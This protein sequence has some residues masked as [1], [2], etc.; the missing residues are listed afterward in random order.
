[1][2]TP[3]LRQVTVM[4]VAVMGFLV[5]FFFVVIGGKDSEDSSRTQ[6]PNVPVVPSSPEVV[7]PPETSPIVLS[8]EMRIA[9]L[10]LELQSLLKTQGKK[11]DYQSAIQ[12]INKDETKERS[13]SRP[14]PPPTNG[15][16]PLVSLPNAWPVLPS[17][18]KPATGKVVRL[19]KSQY[20][21]TPTI[22]IGPG[23]DIKGEEIFPLWGEDFIDDATKLL[24]QQPYD[25]PYDRPED[26]DKNAKPGSI[27]HELITNYRNAPIK[28]LMMR[29]QSAMCLISAVYTGNCKYLEESFTDCA[30]RLG[31][32]KLETVLS[33]KCRISDLWSRTRSATREMPHPDADLPVVHGKV[34][35]SE[36]CPI[37]EAV[38]FVPPSK[39]TIAPFGG[40][41]Q[42]RNGAY[43]YPIAFGTPARTVQTK[44]FPKLFD[45]HPIPV[46]IPPKPLQYN[47]EDTYQALAALSHF[48]ITHSRGGW[49]CGRHY[50]V[51]SAG[52]VPYFYDIH[53]AG[54]FILP[55]LPKKFLM[56]VVK[57]PAMAH[58]GHVT[59]ALN[60]EYFMPTVPYIK[61]DSFNARARV[62]FVNES[63]YFN[64]DKFDYEWYWKSARQFLKY[65]QKYL[66][67]EAMAAYVLK[68]M[69][70]E[71]AKHVLI[72]TRSAWD[73]LHQ[74]FI[75]GLDGLGIKMTI[76]QE[77]DDE[78][79]AGCFRHPSNRMISSSSVA[80][81]RGDIGRGG[82]HGNGV[83]WANRM[84]NKVHRYVKRVSD[85]VD[86]IEFEELYDAAIFTYFAEGAFPLGLVMDLKAHTNGKVAVLDHDDSMGD[87]RRDSIYLAKEVYFFSRELRRAYC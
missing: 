80:N 78:K 66:T 11:I 41:R 22:P 32:E 28:V 77:N 10:Q 13:A 42:C 20:V 15:T 82:L 23:H 31:P 56:D 17:F 79:F 18:R 40:P 8:P 51:A 65:T 34:P 3:F 85:I 5:L 27:W 48:C 57:Q 37:D 19:G 58:I 45:F 73:N 9:K 47:D 67:T 81:L 76:V 24:Y 61:K 59:G 21:P 46:D 2:R 7:P 39:R 26:A 6:A 25:D 74:A 72:L 54:P 52:C 30:A 62:R 12:P 43:H 44:L 64:K 33:E 55:Q 36:L 69:G 86:Q 29:N 83:P 71:N 1:M 50:E 38:D 68:S 70:V 75:T 35:A 60:D 16:H 53:A 49:D 14:L 87:P 63:F 84:R 4:L